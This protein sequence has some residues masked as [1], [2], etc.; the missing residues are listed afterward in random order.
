MGRVPCI[1]SL[2][3]LIAAAAPLHAD[4][5]EVSWDARIVVAAGAG[6][7][8]PWRQNESDF[9][10]VDDATVAITERGVVGVAW[11]D[12]A[13]KDIFFQF[14]EPDGKPRLESPVNV[15]RSPRSFS[16]LPRIVMSPR[17]ADEVQVLWQEIVFAGGSHGGEIFHARSL[18]GGRTF[19]EPVNLSRTTG[20]AGKGRLTKTVWHNGSLDLVMGGEGN[21]YAAWT[22]YEGALRF[23]RS[24]DRGAS[25]SAPLHIAGGRGEPPARGPALAV[26]ATG[27]VFLAWTVGEDPAADIY[28]AKSTDRGRSFGKPRP[29]RRSQGHA[30]APKIAVDG[31]GVVHLVY[32]E[33]PTG[34]FR[35]HHILYTRSGDGG[36]S[37]EEP[38][39]ISGGPPGGFD[40]E[41]FPML[42]LDGAG[43]LYVVWEL[44]TRGVFHP[45]GLAFSF[46]SDGGRSFAA[47]A[48]IPDSVPAE[49]GVNGSQ[50]GLL[51]RKLA[52]NPAGAIALANS[53]FWRDE[54]SEVWLMRGRHAAQP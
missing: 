34:M 6:R 35:G 54:R 11:A 19:T 52:V 18:D 26:D 48:V 21:L 36:D 5:L 28:F 3:A 29:V 31:K 47:P 2:A 51:M 39:A 42:G 16:W 12:Q 25:F 45:R 8:G 33:S 43:N 27:A 4:P 46:S 23:S 22:E 37:F 41:H 7:R 20:G 17:D 38:R 1:F 49:G 15:S 10:Y 24:T 40:H 14:Y 53:T 32:A 44:F 13:R 30:D 9:R 50:Q